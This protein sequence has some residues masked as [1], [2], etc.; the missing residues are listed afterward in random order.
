MKERDISLDAMKGFVILLVMLGHILTLNE[1][2]DLYLYPMIEAVQM[3]AFIMVSG[4]IMGLKSPI[5][6]G[7]QW[8]KILKK[9]AVSYLIPFFGWLILKQ[10]DN[11][12]QGVGDT[13]IQLDRGLW[14]LM[15]LFLLNLLLYT[16]Q[17]INAKLQR[18]SDLIDFFRFCI[19]FGILSGIIAV[20]Y[21]LGNT[22][23]SPELTLKYIP[24]FMLGYLAS[25]Y[26][27]KWERMKGSK[28][29]IVSVVVSMVGFVYLCIHFTLF[30][31]PMWA[32]IKGILGCYVIFYI[33]L[34]SKE[35][36]IKTQL[37]FLGNYTLEIYTVHFHFI[38]KRLSVIKLDFGLYSLKGVLF[39]IAS[40][41]V[42]SAMSAAFIFLAKQS[43]ITNLFM[44]GK[45]SG[46][47]Y[48][49]NRKNKS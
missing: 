5:S 44:F 37:A 6:T 47:T 24:P 22:F 25:R 9:R 34:R 20:Q 13:L 19:I 49:F 10:W 28:I 39:V 11:L 3:P 35:N 23:L 30:A 16:A 31:S 40:F 38:A 45:T 32:M 8:K 18:K 21:M 2:N 26:K 33:F 1:I 14:F 43:F 48:L 36:V 15:T 4:Y 17:F 29:C 12:I 42:M 27:D 46:K 7:V 41:L